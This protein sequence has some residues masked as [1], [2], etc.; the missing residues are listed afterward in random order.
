MSNR[1]VIDTNVWVLL[2]KNP[3]EIKTLEELDCIEVVG[4]WFSELFAQGFYLVVDSYYKI[5]KEYRKNIKKGGLA[6]QY[7]NRLETQPRDYLIEVEGIAWDENGDAVLPHVFNIPDRSDRKFIAVSL[8]SKQPYPPI[9]NATDSDW[10]KVA[11]LLSQH[12]IIV[13]ELC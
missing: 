13:T 2:D 5:F 12:E 1:F 6:E 10:G 8:A 9:I 7:L 4:K 11:D 3:S